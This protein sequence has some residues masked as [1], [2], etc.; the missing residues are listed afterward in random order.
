MPIMFGIM[1]PIIGIMPIMFGIIGI[2]GM[3]IMALPCVSRCGK[4]SNSLTGSE[5]C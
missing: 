1:P 4:W 2:I 5:Q 3:F